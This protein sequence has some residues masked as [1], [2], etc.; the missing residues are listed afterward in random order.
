MHKTSFNNK[1]VAIIVG[2]G[3][4]PVQIVNG[5]KALGVDFSIVRFQGVPADIFSNENLIEATFERISDLFYELK[6]Q[7]FNAVVCCGYIPRPKLN[8]SEISIDSHLIL[9]PIMKNFISGDEAIFLS[10]LKLFKDMNL[11]PLSISELVPNLFPTEEFL[12]RHKPIESD[13]I[14]AERSEQI[15]EVTSSADLGQSLV[16]SKGVCLAIETALGTDAML[17]FLQN[18]KKNDSSAYQGGILYKAPKKGQNQFI[19]QPVIGL[20]T[21]KGVKQAGLSGIVIK[22]SKVICLEPEKIINLA[23]DLG[24]FIWSKK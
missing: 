14:D 24:I 11:M 4:L 17:D 19:D 1:K 23:D 18:V 9:E 22:H 12:T 7:N 10:I 3:D 21:I 20:P 8:F 2:S 15:L 13:I 6:S 16:V 5:A